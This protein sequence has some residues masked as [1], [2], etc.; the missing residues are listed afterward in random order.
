MNSVQEIN[1]LIEDIV[2]RS[3]DARSC[4]LMYDTVLILLE[5][6]PRRRVENRVLRSLKEYP[7]GVWRAQSSNRLKEGGTLNGRLIAEWRT[8]RTAEF[9]TE[10]GEPDGGRNA[11]RKTDRRIENFEDPVGVWRTQSSDRS[12]EGRTLN[13]R[14]ISEWRT[15]RR[16]ERLTEDREPDGGRDARRKAE[17]PTEGGTINGGRNA[18]RTT[19]RQIENST[20]GG[21]P[22]G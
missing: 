10:D 1:P 18:Q 21:M 20:E 7:V 16:S 22:D 15:R 8:R 13:R 4:R 14:R 3:L 2:L 11:Q 19:D 9:P 12:K 5:G 6:G 17:S